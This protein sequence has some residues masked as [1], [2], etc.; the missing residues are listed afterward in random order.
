MKTQLDGEW[1]EILG[2]GP[3]PRGVHQMYRT[4]QSVGRIVQAYPEE[5]GSMYQ[6]NGFFM[7]RAEEVPQDTPSMLFAYKV[8]YQWEGGMTGL[9]GPAF[10]AGEL[11]LGAMALWSPISERSQY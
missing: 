5:L 1:H 6:A 11:W 4:A 3:T 9:V 7:R 2:Q 8:Q 10:R